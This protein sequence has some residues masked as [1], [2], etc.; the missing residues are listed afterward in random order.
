MLF[1]FRKE[2][3]EGYIIH[4][5]AVRNIPLT[6]I[7]EKL[8]QEGYLGDEE[9]F[10]KV[11]LILF[12]DNSRF[13]LGLYANDRSDIF[14]LCKDFIIPDSISSDMDF[15]SGMFLHWLFN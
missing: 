11:D 13:D 3:E 5:F 12:E 2:Q 1:E 7:E 15:I 8:V 14:W 4:N 6:H 9:S 10:N